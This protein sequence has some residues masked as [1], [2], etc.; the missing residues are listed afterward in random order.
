MMM[1]GRCGYCSFTLLS[2]TSPDSPGMRM[3]DTITCGW[4]WASA[5]ITSYTDANVR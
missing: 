5:C 3:S 2:S 1:T 4:V